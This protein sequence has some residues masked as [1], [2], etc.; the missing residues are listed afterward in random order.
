MVYAMEAELVL[1]IIVL[2]LF[3]RSRR[4]KSCP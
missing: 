2:N 1:R 4:E 3:D